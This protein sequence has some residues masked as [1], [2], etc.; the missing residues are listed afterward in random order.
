MAHESL[1]ILTL[2][3]KKLGSTALNPILLKKKKKK[4]K[5][6]LLTENMPVTFI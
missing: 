5:D 4:K 6:A 2:C 1:T 3:K